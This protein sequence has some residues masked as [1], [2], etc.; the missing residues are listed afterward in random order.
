MQR[1]LRWHRGKHPV[2][3]LQV[4]CLSS[5]IG[6]ALSATPIRTVMMIEWAVCRGSEGDDVQRSAGMFPRGIG[7]YD[8]GKIATD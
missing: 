4:R 8:T 1:V 7:A 5:P 6:A 3:G 2:R